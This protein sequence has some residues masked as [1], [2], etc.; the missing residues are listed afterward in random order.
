MKRLGFI[1]DRLPTATLVVMSALAF[2]LVGR[3]SLPV[4]ISD[5]WELLGQVTG[6][7]PITAAWLVAPHYEHSMPL[8]KAVYVFLG[9]L[10]G[11]ESTVPNAVNVG[12]L[13]LAAWLFMRCSVAVRGRV[14][15]LDAVFPILLLHWG[16]WENMV[17]PFQV[18]FAMTAVWTALA[19]LGA[20]RRSL[21][22]VAAACALAG[23]KNLALSALLAG[24]LAT[25]C[26]IGYSRAGMWGG[27]KSHPGYASRYAT[28]M[29]PILA[30][31]ILSVS[32]RKRFAPLVRGAVL[33]AALLL[34]PG[35][36]RS[37][38]WLLESQGRAASLM[39]ECAR[40]GAPDPFLAANFGP[41]FTSIESAKVIEGV[42]ALRRH[43]RMPHPSETP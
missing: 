6:D 34:L 1:L 12:L 14:S 5:E 33:A 31:T 8:T 43:G 21:P 17:H 36:T 39:Q 29:A 35:N 38:T 19:A 37:G 22:M 4:P 41:R 3:F 30:V 20:I 24:L 32:G 9:R 26:A 13:A 40:Q 16:H 15:P 42:A 27:P 11:G 28:I 18:G 25:A 2:V 23:R 10:S 7:V